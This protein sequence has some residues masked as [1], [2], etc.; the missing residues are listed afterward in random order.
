MNEEER[1]LKLLTNVDDEYHEIVKDILNHEEFIKRKNF[2]HHENRSVY[3]HCL[4]VSIKAYKVA[5][6]LNLDKNKAAIGGLLH[7]FYLKDW[8]KTIHIKKSFFKLHGFTHSKEALENSK[9]YFPTLVDKKISN[10]IVRHMFP[11]TPIPPLYLESW[12]VTIVDK[13]VSLE[14]FKSP[15]ELPKY[16][17]IKRKE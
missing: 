3:V 1:I 13:Y 15:K 10:I 6:K 17:G 11:L 4:T 12:I 9:N 2:H 8:Q 5:K 7:D 16:I 14:I